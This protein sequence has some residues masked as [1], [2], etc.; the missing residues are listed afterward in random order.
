MSSVTVRRRVRAEPQEVWDRVTDVRAHGAHVPLTTMGQDE[1]RLSLGARFVAR[2]AVGPLGADDSMLVSG[3]E[4][5]PADP[6]EMRM[7]KTGRWLSGWAAIRVRR[8]E[9][10]AE[11]AWTE[12]I[13]PAPSVLRLP[14]RVLDPLNRRA[15]AA[16]LARVLDGVLAGL[17]RLDGRG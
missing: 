14:A 13:V 16:L 12:E 7:V 4:P 5:P 6:A 1:P 8:V 2:T 3:W 9:G 15:T 10:G 11:V 17:D